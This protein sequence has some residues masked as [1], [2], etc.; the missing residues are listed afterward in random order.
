[1]ENTPNKQQKIRLLE[2]K[3]TSPQVNTDDIKKQEDRQKLQEM[4]AQKLSLIEGTGD[5]VK[6]EVA[7]SRI[8]KQEQLLQS[9]N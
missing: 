9:L 8:Q 2:V 5:S 4:I 7:S 6:T 3:N 1:M